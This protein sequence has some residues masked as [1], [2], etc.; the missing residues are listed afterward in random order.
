M[1]SVQPPERTLL[2]VED[3]TAPSRSWLVRIVPPGAAYGLEDRLVNKDDQ[4]M[5]EFFDPRFP[6][7]VLGDAVIDRAGGEEV[8]LPRGQGLSGQ[9]VSRYS[10]DRFLECRGGLD[11]LGGVDSWKVGA[12]ALENLQEM[13]AAVTGYGLEARL[14]KL[15]ADEILDEVSDALH[16][17]ADAQGIPEGEERDAWRLARLEDHGIDPRSEDLPRVAATLVAEMECL[18]SQRAPD[19]DEDAPDGP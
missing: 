8:A 17:A 7:V 12:E 13:V 2:L 19:A 3:A 15:S 11:L 18:V 5:V 16:E 9:F 1:I 6:H 4:T 10:L 14:R